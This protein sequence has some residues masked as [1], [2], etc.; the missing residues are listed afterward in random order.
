MRCSRRRAGASVAER[1]IMAMNERSVE[2]TSEHDDG[3]LLKRLLLTARE[4]HRVVVANHRARLRVAWPEEVLGDWALPGGTRFREALQRL[5]GQERDLARSCEPFFTNGVLF[6]GQG[7]LTEEGERAGSEP[8]L[9]LDR[10]ARGLRV[11]RDADGVT[12]S[13][14]VDTSRKPRIPDDDGGVLNA[15]SQ[16]PE[17]HRGAVKRLGMTLVVLPEYENPGHHD[18]SRKELDRS[19]SLIPERHERLLQAALPVAHTST[20]TT[21]WAYCEHRFFHRFMGSIRDGRPLVHWNGTTNPHAK[22]N[23]DP[24]EYAPTV[25]SDVPSDLRERLRLLRVEGCGC[26]EVRR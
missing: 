22:Q 5:R 20:S 1:A 16:R 2:G 13:F 6:D 26:R 17:G 4:I 10:L 14:D 9:L 8:F 12:I 21:W 3:E 15:W 11:A 25:E 19:R 7:F 24:T 18:P 23:R